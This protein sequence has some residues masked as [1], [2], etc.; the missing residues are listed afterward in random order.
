MSP[1]D[2]KRFDGID[3]DFKEL[4]LDARKTPNVVEATNKPGLYSKLEDMQSRFADDFSLPNLL[5]S[6]FLSYIKKEIYGRMLD[7]L[8]SLKPKLMM[9]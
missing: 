1:Q 6:F 4:A 3:I 9:S 2:S 5:K 7:Q 8:F